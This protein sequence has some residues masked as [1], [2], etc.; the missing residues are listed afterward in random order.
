MQPEPE[1]PSHEP[2]PGP[3]WLTPD[4]AWLP[5]VPP[6]PPGPPAPPESS[7]PPPASG[8]PGQ[9]AG[10]VLLAV[11]MIAGAVFGVGIATKLRL[12][13]S[14]P[15]VSPS[16][17]PPTSPFSRNRQGGSVT[18]SSSSSLSPAQ[19]SAIAAKVTSGLVDINTQLGYQG[20]AGAGTGMLLTSSGEVLTNNHVIDGATKIQVTLVDTGKSYNATVVGTD[21]T[22]DIAIIQVS[23]LSGAKTVHTG[24]SSKVAVGDPV[25]AM[26]N[27]G[28][29]GG[30]PEVVSGTVEA[31]NQTITASD[32]G[33]ANAETLTG[34]IQT[35]API[36]PGDSG[37]PLVNTA[38]EVIGMNTAASAGRRFRSGA[39]VGFAIPIAKA[40]SI[41][42][43][44]A[45]GQASN[46]IHI[47]VPGFL[48]VA[49]DPNSATGGASLAGVEP[50]S[51]A[52]KAGLVAG[53]VIT[54][55]DGK[56]VDSPDALSA[57]THAHK[58]GDK[59]SVSWTDQSGRGRKA[60]LT[61]A[62]GPPD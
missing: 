30:A 53:D 24:N 61:L 20:G 4:D 47:G 31:I 57:I 7:S 28:G 5:P 45:S 41:G 56:A 44:I 16:V 8:S 35:D 29:S 1:A 60:T 27:A 38:S 18:S 26:G 12:H 6:G 50:G 32:P 46:A 51:P 17:V 23:G 48:G 21:P 36:Q 34:L 54:S 9:R 43:Q 19:A 15:T 14:R 37:G 59:V 22:D 33:G 49:L 58:P 55:I 2:Q 62:A 11:A 3:H 13:A 40:L 10:A 39:Q 52:A 25:V 42:K